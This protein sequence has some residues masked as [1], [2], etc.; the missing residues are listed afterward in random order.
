MASDC[1]WISGRSAMQRQMT[2]E[3]FLSQIQEIL[4]KR[5]FA[6]VGASRDQSKFGYQVYKTLKGAGYATYAVNPNA[7][8]IDGD[9]V[10][11]LLDNV[12]VKPDCAVTVVQ[13]EVTFEICRQCGH[14]GI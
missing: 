8:S 12:P 10:Y 6:V 5:T 1:V 9:E 7:E 4:S 13:P 11:P 2:H 14:L 3:H